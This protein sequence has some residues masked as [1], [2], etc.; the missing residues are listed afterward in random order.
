MRSCTLICRSGLVLS[1]C[2][3]NLSIILLCSIYV[4][5]CITRVGTIC[6][7]CDMIGD[8]ASPTHVTRSCTEITKPKSLSGKRSLLFFELSAVVWSN[9]SQRLD[10]GS[11]AT[12]CFAVA[13]TAA[14]SAPVS[15]VP[16]VATPPASSLPVWSPLSAGGG[17]LAFTSL[18]AWLIRCLSFCLTKMSS[19]LS[20]SSFTL[21]MFHISGTEY[22]STTRTI[23]IVKTCVWVTLL[24][25]SF[26]AA[27][28]ICWAFDSARRR[29]RTA[30][31][32]VSMA[33]VGAVRYWCSRSWP[34]SS[35]LSCC[36]SACRSDARSGANA[37]RK[38][39]AVAVSDSARGSSVMRSTPAMRRE[40]ARSLASRPK[41]SSKSSCSLR[42]VAWPTSAA[43]SRPLPTF[44]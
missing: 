34:S 4:Q 15:A 21:T 24:T 20:K 22:S 44:A 30:E 19:C 9:F 6:F 37:V 2:C 43:F 39:R 1:I 5:P 28:S 12:P 13:A 23:Q 41:A 11:A 8:M 14:F 32:T 16:A 33:T 29:S 42:L 31:A 7:A 38:C 36:T 35:T 25:S 27:L 26:A 17:S 18:R 10:H 40:E 3:C